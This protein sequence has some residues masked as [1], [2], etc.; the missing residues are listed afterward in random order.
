MIVEVRFLAL[1]AQ[2]EFLAGWT[3]GG[4][5]E[6]PSVAYLNRPY[7]FRV[8]GG[9]HHQSPTFGLVE[10]GT[11]PAVHQFRVGPYHLIDLIILRTKCP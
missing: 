11:H 1:L 2:T 4:R 6:N 9:D 5:Q 3:E 10:Q 7:V 8:V